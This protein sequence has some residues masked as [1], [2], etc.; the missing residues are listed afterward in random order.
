[1]STHA[2]ISDAPGRQRRDP[3]AHAAAAE[4]ILFFTLYLAIPEEEIH[5]DADDQRKVKQNG[6]P[7]TARSSAHTNL[8]L[9]LGNLI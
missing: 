3:A 9:S 6:D 5:T 1:M 4:E 8:P 2:L 7:F